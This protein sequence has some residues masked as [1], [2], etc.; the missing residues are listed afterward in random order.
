M[1]AEPHYGDE[2]LL[3]FLADEL[4]AGRKEAVAQHLADCSTCRRA[5]GELEGDYQ[6]LMQAGGGHPAL[7]PE[8]IRKARLDLA[9]AID[10]HERDR[11]RLAY[12]RRFARSLKALAA[13]AGLAACFAGILLVV[14]QRVGR[15]GPEQVLEIARLSEQ[16]RGGDVVF[17]SFGVE[18]EEL[19]PR[20]EQ[21][22]GRLEAWSDHGGGRFASRWLDEGGVLKHAVWHPA[23]APEGFTYDSSD[24]GRIARRAPAADREAISLV[25]LGAYGLTC[26][27]LAAGFVR[28]LETRSWRRVTLSEGMLSLVD[29]HGVGL[30]LERA[31]RD[32]G[33]RLRLAAR[34]QTGSGVVEVI[35]EV[36]AGNY[37]PLLLRVRYDAGER[38]SEVRIARKEFRPVAAGSVN[39]VVFEP[40]LPEARAEAALAGRRGES[41][42]APASP[43]SEAEATSG[44]DRR[45]AE[46][47]ILYALHEAG[48]C[49][50]APVQVIEQ[51]GGELLVTGIVRSEAMKARILAGLA[52]MK[53]PRRIAT[54]IVTNEEA[55]E[56]A[57]AGRSLGAV[58]GSDRP[59]AT[60]EPSPEIASEQAPPLEAELRAYF[61]VQ[62]LPDASLPAVDGSAQAGERVA[63]FTNRAATLAANALDEA[64]ALRTLADGYGELTDLDLA[65]AVLLKQMIEDHLGALGDETARLRGWASPVLRAIAAGRGL[66]VAGSPRSAR[67]TSPRP[68]FEIW[69][70]TCR[71][72]F[73]ATEQMHDDVMALLAVNLKGANGT[74]SED[75]DGSATA[76][77]IE[78]LLRNLDRMDAVAARAN[79]GAG[80]GSPSRGDVPAGTPSP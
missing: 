25:D 72:A 63:A 2:V 9:A 59:T 23:S 39:P 22:A 16:A 7:G 47:R 19:R 80:L 11:T 75:G 46:I 1:R 41:Q 42:S 3:D 21:V 49:L 43:L 58:E 53:L 52:G 79:G 77:A 62:P 5:F 78:R 57:R 24:P 40:M 26:D 15:A 65:S 28:W 37:E 71:E 18:I 27:E 32:R 61:S 36:D 33:D 54:D 56:R 6:S 67:Q 64:W 12:R 45:G 35:L 10:A 60:V 4:P 51:Q 13:V 69:P 68:L 29:G 38:V 34:R 50:G 14:R 31:P 20:R 70:A 48:A 44:A 55:A 73:A 8:R 66:E 76:K 30:T 74:R 17:Q